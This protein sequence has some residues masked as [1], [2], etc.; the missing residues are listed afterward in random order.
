MAEKLLVAPDGA[1]LDPD[2]KKIL[3]KLRNKVGKAPSYGES[4][5]VL[6]QAR[7][8]KTPAEGLKIPL[9]KTRNAYGVCDQTEQLEYGTCFFQPTIKGRPQVGECNNH[10]WEHF[11]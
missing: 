10:T 7:Q 2:T 5:A 8:K 9:E 11:T 1:P 3:V 4:N 6:L